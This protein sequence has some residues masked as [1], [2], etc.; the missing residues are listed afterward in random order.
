MSQ[1]RQALKEARIH[2]KEL[3]MVN[4]QVPEGDLPFTS[5]LDLVTRANLY[6]AFTS[7]EDVDLVELANSYRSARRPRIRGEEPKTAAKGVLPA[8]QV[9]RLLNISRN[10]GYKAIRDGSFPIAA[11]R[12]GRKI[13]FARAAVRELLGIDDDGFESLLGTPVAHQERARRKPAPPQ[14]L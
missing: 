2:Q 7:I 13:R 1:E 11:I 9:F 4:R 10:A 3:E 6:P 5:A 12:I 14:Q 8:H